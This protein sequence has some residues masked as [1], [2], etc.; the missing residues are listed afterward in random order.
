MAKTALKTAPVVAVRAADIKPLKARMTTESALN[1]FHTHAKVW[2]KASLCVLSSAAVCL[3]VGTYSEP[4]TEHDTMT[5]KLRA[6]V[7][8]VGVKEAQIY[9][10]LGL[11]KALVQHIAGEH[12]IGGP[13]PDVVN[14]RK[15]DEAMEI[16]LKYL[17]SKGVRS[18][19]A[20]GVMV[21]KYGRAEPKDEDENE[22]TETVQSGPHLVPD[23]PPAVP[24]RAAAPAIA[25]RIMAEPAVLN[26]LEAH[27]IVTSYVKAG[28]TAAALI[29][30][31]IDYI[32]TVREVNKLL[33][34]LTKK[35][36]ALEA[37]KERQAA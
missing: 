37:H 25:A 12:L 36:E 19:D 21:G 18:L 10:Y 33:N 2:H 27:E 14:S 26:N 23:M 13:I 11:A 17:T 28:N 34:K 3:I 6:K 4:R 16:I 30:S 22:D 15:A 9:R 24:T 8:E 32:K 5:E 35:K 29:E 31:A 7:S 20:L 1:A